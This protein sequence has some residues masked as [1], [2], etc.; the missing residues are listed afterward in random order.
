MLVGRQMMRE[1]LMRLCSSFLVQ[2]A[3]H[4]LF[5]LSNTEL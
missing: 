3:Q 1:G 2:Q 5:P 4:C